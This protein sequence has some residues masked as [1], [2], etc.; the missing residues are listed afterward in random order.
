LVVTCQFPITKFHNSKATLNYVPCG[1]HDI[2]L[3]THT[4]QAY[5]AAASFVPKLTTTVL[6]YLDPQPRDRILDIGC[7]D[8]ALT[9]Q[10][11][12][13]LSSGQILGLDASPSMILAAQRS[14]LQSGHTNCT[15]HIQDCTRFSEESSAKYLN[16]SWDKVFSNAALHW[17][18]C[19]LETRNDV[20]R[21][22]HSALKPGGMFVFEMGGFGNCG[23]VYAALLAALVADGV[24]P[25]EAR[26]RS[27]WF[28]PSEEWMQNALEEAGFEVIKMESE[29]RPTKLTA[30]ND[31]GNGGL[32]GWLKLMA[33]Q[34]LEAVRDKDRA[35]QFVA[36]ILQSV[37]TK[38]D[39]TQWI[40]YV[41]LRGMARKGT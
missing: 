21:A 24:S 15:F 40:G 38:Q 28:F 17:I 30:S 22:F 8:G 11:A 20:I 41:R 14:C 16:G 9:L 13:I 35:V 1:I 6:K 18:L 3:L 31:E 32:E 12:S 4:F 19:R 39:G 29:Y 36:D 33:A 7:G 5:K 25:A 26:Q 34:F 2:N 37:I 10:I 23:E 27:P